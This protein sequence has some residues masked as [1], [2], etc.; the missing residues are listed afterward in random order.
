[1]IAAKCSD[2]HL[3]R[4]YRDSRSL[5]EL[6]TP[7]GTP[8]R[9]RLVRI[10]PELDFLDVQD[11]VK[12]ARAFAFVGRKRSL[13]RCLKVMG[14][15]SDRV[16]V[17]IQG[18]GGLGKSTLAARVCR[19]V[20]ALR[21]GVQRVVLVGVALVGGEAEIAGKIG[22]SV[23]TQWVNDSRFVEAL[24]LC[25]RIL[26]V[27]TD[28]RILR[29]IA[30]AEVILGAVESATAHY[31]EALN[32]CP[33]DDLAGR[34]S[35]LFNHATLIAQQGDI[36]RALDLWQQSLE[37]Y[38]RIGNI[39]GK[40]ATLANMGANA[41]KQGDIQRAAELLQQS[42]QA[43]GQVRAYTDLVTALSNLGGITETG[44]LAYF[45]QALW[46][47]LRIQSPLMAALS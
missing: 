45:A 44:N 27:F 14:P 15:T 24:D 6:V 47:C 30:R 7:M 34:S 25:Q 18:M 32:L 33:E 23:A 37:I 26:A 20:Q 9:A 19:R 2:W 38:E 4:V 12:V 5:A 41:Y 35:I 42:A 11:Q 43:L 29:T 1:M 17:F 31:T 21:T 10:Q 16:G 46:L 39:Q 13:Q 40:A 22:H 8:K 3:L 36:D 28:Q